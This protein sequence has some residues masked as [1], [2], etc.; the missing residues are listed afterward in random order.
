MTL[1][2]SMDEETF[3][4]H[5]PLSAFVEDIYGDHMIEPSTSLILNP[6][7]LQPLQR[8]TIDRKLHDILTIIFS[9]PERIFQNDGAALGRFLGY[10][11]EQLKW[12][13]FNQTMDFVPND[14]FIRG[15]LY[16]TKPNDWKLLELNLGSNVGGITITRINRFIRSSPMFSRT[17][18]KKRLQTVDTLRAWADTFSRTIGN[19]E[20]NNVAFI[21]DSRIIHQY[22]NVLKVFKDELQPWIKGDVLLCSQKDL[23]LK[24]GRLYAGHTEI[25]TVYRMFDM[26][27]LERDPRSYE[28]LLHAWQ[29]GHVSMPMGMKYKLLGNKLLFSL[30]KDPAFNHFFTPSERKQID[31]IIPWTRALN[32]KT[33]DIAVGERNNMVVKPAD[34]YGGKGVY[35][36]WAYTKEA[37]NRLIDRLYKQN[38]TYI[39]QEKVD[40]L[41][42]QILH[43]SEETGFHS[44]RSNL[45]WGIYMFDHTFAGG[46]T[47]A[48]PLK[49]SPVINLH[50]G[51]SIGTCLIEMKEE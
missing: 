27:D 50:N 28:P 35:C 7:V 16:E 14:V 48:M 29:N 42:D 5:H 47:R 43:Y 32:E 39:I 24:T 12:I 37:W 8:Q 1:L 40:P 25:H 34:G 10:S 45:L 17:I 49:G 3:G 20:P 23:H 21:E 13:T 26:I 6:P 41:P 38:Q 31:E 30:L 15:D 11:P 36:G 19:R 9:I 18:Q 44:S 4:P 46:V 51:A 2:F 33:K 22:K